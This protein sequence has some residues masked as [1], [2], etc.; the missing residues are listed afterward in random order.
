MKELITDIEKL[1]VAE[2]LKFIT[3]TG[4]DREKGDQIINDLKEIMEANPNMISLAAPQIGEP[5]RI[6]CIRFNDTIKTFIDPIIKKKQGSK[7]V[8]ETCS[9]L[10]GKEIL[11]TRP[12]EITV[13]YYTDDFKYEDNKLV[14]PAA[15]IFDQQI[16]L[17]DGVLPSDLGLVSDIEEDGSLFD[18]TNEEFEQVKEIYKQFIQV[19]TKQA[20]EE[21]IANPELE[22]QYRQLKFSEDVINGRTLILESDEEAETRNILNKRTKAHKIQ[23]KKVESKY[24]F[25]AGVNHVLNRKKGKR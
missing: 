21:A 5:Y 19:K 14:G 12:E 9:L 18:L 10:P 23:A 1:E 20:Q 8:V 13:V 24:E 7:L 22:K 17:L 4:I 16:Q 25:K 6:F 15:A 11:L 3:D 2:P